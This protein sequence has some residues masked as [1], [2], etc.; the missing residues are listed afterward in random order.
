MSTTADGHQVLGTPLAVQQKFMRDTGIR[1]TINVY[2]DVITN[3]ES[4]AFAK[5]APCL[6]KQHA[7]SRRH[8][9]TY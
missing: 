1:T 9:L 3:Q 6:C 7:S 8:R 4:E 5:I 2:G